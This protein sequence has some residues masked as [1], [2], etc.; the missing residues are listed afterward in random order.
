MF[1]NILGVEAKV[2]TE[3][4]HCKSIGKIDLE[5]PY[6]IYA[7]WLVL[8][9][10]YSNLEWGAV[11]TVVNGVVISYQ[12]PKQEV[13][14]TEVTFK[15]ELAGNGMLH[16]HHS[17]HLNGF[18]AQDDTQARNLYEW[19]IVISFTGYTACRKINLPCNGFSYQDVALKIKDFPDLNTANIK[20]KP[21]LNDYMEFNRKKEEARLLGKD[22]ENINDCMYSGDGLVWDNLIERY[23]PYECYRCEGMN[24]E[25]CPVVSEIDKD[26]IIN[27]R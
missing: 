17:M 26:K 10:Q 15:E 14:A 12:I 11:F 24:C 3:C 27:K 4:G 20:E 5:I 2:F 23:V 1:N 13:T 25:D 6:K 19:S 16:S 9:K 7:E 18:S 8:L 22:R 21:I